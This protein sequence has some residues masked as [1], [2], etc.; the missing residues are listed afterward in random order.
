MS[1]VLEIRGPPVGG[2]TIQNG[3]SWPKDFLAPNWDHRI[4][5]VEYTFR[6]TFHLSP[7]P[8][9]FVEFMWE[10]VDPVPNGGSKVRCDGHLGFLSHVDQQRRKFCKENRLSSTRTKI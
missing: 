3:Q 8:N 9:G 2:D 5:Q 7:R 6:C 4:Q 1:R 10:D